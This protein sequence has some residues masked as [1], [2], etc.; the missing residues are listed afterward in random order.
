[1]KYPLADIPLLQRHKVGRERDD[2]PHQGGQGG[3]V[4]CTRVRWQLGPSFHPLD[5]VFVTLFI[6]EGC[7]PWRNVNLHSGSISKHILLIYKKKIIK[8]TILRI[9]NNIQL[10]WSSEIKDYYISFII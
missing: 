3:V 9:E 1:M 7:R 5:Q 2:E 4:A 8:N 10:V 6:L